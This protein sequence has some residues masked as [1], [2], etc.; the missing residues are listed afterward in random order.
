M[1]SEKKSFFKNFPLK[2]LSLLIAFLIWLIVVNVNDYKIV[3]EYYEIPVDQIY[4][5]EIESRGYVYDVISGETVDILVEGRR[6]VLDSLSKSDFEAVADLSKLSYTDTAKI[7]VTCKKAGYDNK[8]TIT[9]KDDALKLSIEEKKAKQFEVKVDTKGS[10][11]DGYALGTPEI[12]PSTV[13]ITG[14]ESLI[15]KIKNVK[16]VVDTSGLKGSKTVEVAISLL[17]G[18]DENVSFSRLDI[19]TTKVKV[20]IPV[21]ET[22]TVPVKFSTKGHVANGYMLTAINEGIDEV[23]V[24]GPAESLDSINYIFVNDIDIDGLTSDKTFERVISD[25]L[26]EG[27]DFADS[28]DKVTVEIKVEKLYEK[29]FKLKSEDIIFINTKSAYDYKVELTDPYELKLIG[30]ERYVSNVDLAEYG[31][32]IDCADLEPGTYELDVRLMKQGKFTINKSGTAVVTISEK[33]EA[34]EDT[35]ADENPSGENGSGEEE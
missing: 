9:V 29:S 24:S 10:V 34:T 21:N 20:T 32:V 16:A 27:V 28:S 22:K 17:D 3:K 7:S 25:Y 1:K 14:P 15:K 4:G 35:G 5:E 31:P 19:D 11:A 26:P 12:S 8:I 6:S 33:E 18:N 2:L 13:S 23:L 30:L